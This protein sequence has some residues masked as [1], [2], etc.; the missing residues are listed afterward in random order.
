MSINQFKP[1]DTVTAFLIRIVFFE[2]F[3]FIYLK[4]RKKKLDMQIPQLI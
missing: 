2:G 3:D 4:K 1:T